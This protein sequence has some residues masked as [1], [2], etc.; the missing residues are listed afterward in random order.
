MIQAGIIG[1]AGYVGGELL[2]LLLQHSE[3]EVAFISS[4]SQAG[5][6][7]YETHRDLLGCTSLRFSPPKDQEVDVLFLCMGHGKS[8]EYL[9]KHTVSEDTVIIDLSRDFRLTADAGSYVYGLCELN[10]AEIKK[11]NYIANPGCFAT[12]IQLALLPLAAANVIKDEVHVTAITGSTG[13]GQ[14]PV[15]TTHFSWRNNNIS[16]YKAFTHQH[17]DEIVQSVS[18]LQKGFDQDVNFIPMRGD[19][20]RGIFAS[21]Y[22]NSSLTEEKAVELFAKYYSDSPFVHVSNSPISVKDVVNTNNGYLYVSKHGKKLRIESAIDNLLKGAAGQAVQNM[23]LVFGL[24]E[25]SGLHLKPSA[26]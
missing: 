18:Q 25:K 13:A 2:R 11:S 24:D 17:L 8:S 9:S 10:K 6:Y 20:P 1:G 3:V 7:V 19:F 26:F 22:L 4:E 15:P 14:K 12:C 23:N 21:V 16:I 5:K